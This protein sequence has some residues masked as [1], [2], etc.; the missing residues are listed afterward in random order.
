[1]K[2]LLA[3]GYWLLVAAA[4]PLAAQE[5]PKT[6][7][8]PG[9]LVPAPFPPFREAT[10]PNG[11]RLL[12]VESRKQPI[13]SL[14]LSFPAGSVHDPAGKEGVAEMVAGLLTK[15]AGNRSAEEVAEA[16]EGAGGSLS[17]GV[18][19]DFLTVNATV[20]TPSLPLAFELMA[21]AAVRP[22]FE[23]KEL[24]LLRLQTLSGLQVALSQ[25]EE[26]A[27]RTFRRTLYG[28]HPYAR[29]ATPASVQ[30]ITRDDLM[31]FHR[32]RIKPGEALLVIAG[33]ISFEEARR[34][35]TQAFQGWTGSG[36]SAPSQGPTEPIL[37]HRP[38]RLVLVHRP[39][40]VQSNILAGN[41]TYPPNDPRTYAS[42]VANQVLGG[43]ASS[44]LFII[45]REQKS[46]T[47]GAYSQYIRRQDVGFFLASTEVR[48]EVTDSALGE[49]LAQLR[50][51]RAEPVP[52]AELESAKS[53][54]VGQYPLTI[55]T[56]EQ[57]AAAVANARLHGLPADFVQTYRVRLGQVTGAEVQQTVQTT[58]LPDS[59]VIV[60]VGDGAKIYDRIK[61]LAPVTI[62][63]PEGKPLAADDLQPKA[64]AVDLD[65]AALTARR[66]SFTVI[67]QGQPQGW[68][69]QELEPLPDGFRYTERLDIGG[70]VQQTTVLELDHQAG[71]RSVKQTGKVMGQ[72]V[73]VDVQYRNGRAVGTARTPD[74]ATM[75][76]KSVTI[77]TTVMPGTLDDNALQALLPTLRWAAGAKWTFQVFGAG[78][79]KL[80]TWTLSVA[81]TDTLTI[82]GR[83]VETYRADL[84]GG[85]A[86]LTLWVTTKAPYSL[87]KIGV[88]GGPPLEFVR[89][90]PPQ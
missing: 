27:G 15:G 72:D 23:D 81:G 44:R 84:A 49:L 86:P 68:H 7:P 63:D 4:P 41:L 80:S 79:A 2:R 53:A 69:T 37:V 58:I 70:F 39:G 40:S 51:I 16:I 87:M 11:L 77:D 26:I 75:Q 6:P 17:A 3:I 36:P 38:A 12:V 52:P 61:G 88:L 60:V 89:A 73:T 32:A 14:S 45:L 47:Y 56:A 54:L 13:V 10:L 42:T 55:E 67:L 71:V 35:A 29:S 19:A 25:P 82:S 46:W 22:R 8:P 21:D 83:P 18:S 90:T 5:Y 59:L 50:R 34:L 66:D 78:Q 57:V 9:P 43:G 48:T 65:L 30:A 85:D 64:V 76:I 20:L 28:P 74:P 31:G 1:M 24:G 62:Q 33:A